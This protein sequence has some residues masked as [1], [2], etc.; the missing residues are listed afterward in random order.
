MTSARTLAAGQ[1]SADNGYIS[2][3]AFGGIIEKFPFAS[4]GN[5]ASVGNLSN[6]RGYAAGQNSS[7]HG[8]NSGGHDRAAGG[9]SSPINI[10]EKFTFAS[11]NNGTDVGDLTLARQ[12]PAGQS[13]TDNGYASGGWPTDVI[14]KFPFSSDSNSTD[15]GDLT[16]LRTR[17][18]GQS[19]AASGYT[20]GGFASPTT[21]SD[22]ID[23]FPFSSDGNATDVGD[24]TAGLQY[25]GGH[26]G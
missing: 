7:T 3:G 26:Q 10:I 21:M 1:S 14:D 22:T 11:D 6:D 8:Y 9:T 4:D 18:S 20:S 17:A 2:G 16:V 25:I 13:S 12:S 15:I 19:S 23:K 5:S 24:L